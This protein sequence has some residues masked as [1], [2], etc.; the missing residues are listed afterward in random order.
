[1]AITVTVNPTF[2]KLNDDP[3]YSR[4]PGGLG[5]EVEVVVDV[6]ITESTT[7][8]TNGLT[9]SF[10][11]TGLGLRQVYLCNVVQGAGGFVTEFVPGANNDASTGK[12]KFYGI[13][14]A[15]DGGSVTALDEIAN[16][17]SL[18]QGLTLKCVIRGVR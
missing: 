11:G 4:K 12:I 15:A 3:S 9:V 17:S 18:I 2:K 7:Y 5:R 6:A 8:T 14:E 13:N 16:G 10:A 1:M